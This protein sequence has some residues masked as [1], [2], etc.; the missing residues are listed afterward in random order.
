[1]WNAGHCN[2]Q[3]YKKL[4]AFKLI[5]CFKNDE[6]PSNSSQGTMQYNWTMKS[7]SQ[8][9]QSLPCKNDQSYQDWWEYMEKSSRYYAN[10]LDHEYRLQWSASIRSSYSKL[11]K[12]SY[13]QHW[14][15]LIKKVLNLL[16]KTTGL[17]NEGCSDC[18]LWHHLPCQMIN[19]SNNDENT[20][21][22]FQIFSK[23]T[24]HKM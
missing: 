12:E 2:L 21:M 16:N 4:S 7:R 19:H 17:R 5:S 20:S 6:N 13:Q 15:M 9:L 22:V 14:W 18:V 3:V 8:W 10:F 24:D 1:M 23:I 11:H